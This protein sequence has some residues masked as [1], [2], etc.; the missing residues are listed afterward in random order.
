MP[1]LS[2]E[3]ARGL[4]LSRFDASWGGL[5]TLKLKC[6]LQSD[7]SATALTKL[8]LDMVGGVY[9]GELLR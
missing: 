5:H 3:R 8:V 4:I 6:R 1:V 2:G 7:Q 9:P